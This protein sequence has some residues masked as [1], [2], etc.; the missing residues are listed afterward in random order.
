MIGKAFTLV[1]RLGIKPLVQQ[2]IKG[3]PKAHGAVRLPKGLLRHV[4]GWQAGNRALGHG[5][6][7]FLAVHH[8]KD[9]AAAN[10]L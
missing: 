9:V 6:E 5:T 2:K 8:D 1:Q 10:S 3:G 4:L 7:L